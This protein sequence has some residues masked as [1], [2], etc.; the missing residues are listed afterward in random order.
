MYCRPT[1]SDRIFTSQKISSLKIV[2]SSYLNEVTK[3]LK[4][5]TNSF[6]QI[7]HNNNNAVKNRVVEFHVRCLL[8]LMGFPIYTR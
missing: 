3:S 4:R 1:T 6:E 7:V 2:V 5:V 8:S